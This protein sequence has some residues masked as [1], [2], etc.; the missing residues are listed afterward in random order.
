MKKLRA[1]AVLLTIWAG[2]NLLLAAGI[3]LAMGVFG[4]HPPSLP[5]ALS[6]VEIRALSPKAVGLMH[7]LASLFNAAA[8][9]YFGLVLF[10]VRTA[11]ATHSRPIFRAVGVSAGFLQVFGFVSDA[12]LGNLNVGANILSSAVLL[13]A[14]ALIS[15]GLPRGPATFKSPE[16]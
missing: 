8:V 2:L 11:V 15:R 6:D 1:G 10:L 5:M 12:Y 14:F 7:A 16:R 4:R 3:L 9:A 13:L